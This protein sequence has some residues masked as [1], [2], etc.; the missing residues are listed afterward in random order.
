[1]RFLVFI[2]ILSSLTAEANLVSNVQSLEEVG[3]DLGIRVLLRKNFRSKLTTS[4]WAKIRAVLSRRPNVGF[5]VVKA[6]DNQVSLRG[7]V[8]DKEANKV[9][10][11]LEKADALMLAEKF[12][13][14]FTQYQ[15][16]AKYIKKS[17]NNR[18]TRSLNQLYLNVL[19]QMA[20]AL[21]SA[22]RFQESLDVYA[23]IPP[24]YS[25]TR[26]VM[27]EK[28]WTAFR[29]GRIDLAL[30][31]I[32]SQQ[33]EFFSKY[34]D[35]ESYLIKIYLL[36][37]LCREREFKTTIESVRDYLQE[38]KSGEF[39][40]MDWARADLSRMSLAKLL[41]ED[42]KNGD[43][44][45]LDLVSQE[46]REVE[47]KKI[48]AYLQKKFS[49]QKK[50]LELQLTKVLGYGTIAITQEQR[51]LS[52]VKSLPESRI[53][54]AQGFELWP[55]GTGEEWTDEIGSHVFIGESQCK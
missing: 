18:I 25:Q 24:V 52:Q 54:E 47:R 16:V 9:T 21:Y 42:E 17:N 19:H 26:Q 51:Q 32:A 4:D 28:M 50:R 38:L 46:D 10:A 43:K 44:I 8:L 15:V 53:L 14:A 13:A 12:E 20:R 3:D 5:D 7:T 22:G 39:T 45:L 40:Y 55:A 48:R 29:A 33:S 49:E 41:Q 11:A 34:L 37:R 35:P 23:W 1:M 2:L 30:G 27:F 31:A 6:W 36:K